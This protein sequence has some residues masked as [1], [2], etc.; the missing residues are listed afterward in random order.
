M[1]S[2]PNREGG[3]GEEFEAVS[4]DRGK[5]SCANS[6]PSKGAK[7]R[8]TST[9]GG[10]MGKVAGRVGSARGEVKQIPQPSLRDWSE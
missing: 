9:G 1:V 10:A 3:A 2:D 6:H 4:G 5:G 8:A 7:S